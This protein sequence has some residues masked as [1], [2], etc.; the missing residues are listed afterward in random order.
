MSVSLLSACHAQ[1]SNKQLQ[2]ARF[3]FISNSDGEP[4]PETL[5]QGGTAFLPMGIPAS[6]WVAGLRAMLP[7]SLSMLAQLKLSLAASYLA[8]LRL[9]S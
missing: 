1:E 2:E 5:H 3:E 9:L 6:Q 7:P 4:V 8:F